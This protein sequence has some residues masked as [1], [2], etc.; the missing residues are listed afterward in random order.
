MR[1]LVAQAVA[2]ESIIIPLSFASD[3]SAHGV[4]NLRKIAWSNFGAIANI[5]QDGQGIDVHG[6]KFDSHRREHVL[7]AP[8]R[9]ELL[10]ISPTAPVQHVSW[11]SSGLDLV[12]VDSAGRITI[13][14]TLVALNRLIVRG[15]FDTREPDIYGEVIELKWLLINRPVCLPFL[16]GQ[17]WSSPLMYGCDVV[18]SYCG[19]AGSWSL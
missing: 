18:S 12:V 13:Y 10:E 17:D 3:F 5:V 14:T 1:N 15:N 2:S 6:L 19:G 16:A 4:A 9:L 7:T 11:S 8:T